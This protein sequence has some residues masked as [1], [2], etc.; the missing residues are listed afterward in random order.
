M[1]RPMFVPKVGEGGQ[2]RLGIGPFPLSGLPL[3]RGQGIEHE[4]GTQVEVEG[5]TLHLVPLGIEL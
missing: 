4:M 5:L 2:S 3:D 1:D